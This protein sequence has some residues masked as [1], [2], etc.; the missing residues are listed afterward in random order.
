MFHKINFVE[1]FNGKIPALYCLN[2]IIFIALSSS[3]W[4]VQAD[5]A[6]NLSSEIEGPKVSQPNIFPESESAWSVQAD[7]TNNLR[8][9]I[10]VPNISQPN[11]EEQNQ[12]CRIVF[13]RI[14]RPIDDRLMIGFPIGENIYSPLKVQPIISLNSESLI[15]MPLYSNSYWAMPLLDEEKQQQRQEEEY[16]LLMNDFF[17]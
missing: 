17:E 11:T 7:I 14:L 16:F 6:N 10:E 5:I 13:F 9:E 4:F 15:G 8:A 12:Q 1:W 2:L 3:A